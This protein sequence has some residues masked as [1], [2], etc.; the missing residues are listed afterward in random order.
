MK[1]IFKSIGHNKRIL[2]L[3]GIS[4]AYLLWGLIYIYHSSFIA[5]DGRRY[6]SLFDDAMI[7]MRYAWNFSHGLGL[8]WNQGE[9]V[10]GYTN[11]LMVLLM[12]ITTLLFDKSRAALAVQLSGIPIM[13]GIAWLTTRIFRF[14]NR[15]QETGSPELM[16][17]ILFLAVLAY[18]PLSFWS[19]T[20]METGLLALLLLGS[21]YA[22]L[23]YIEKQKPIFLLLTSVLLGFAFLTRNDA[24]IY[25]AWTFIYLG[26]TTLHK[27]ADL[28]RFVVN[29]AVFG[30]FVLI[31]EAIRYFYYGSLV[32]NT[33]V[34][35]LVGMSLANRL[36]N[37]WGFMQLFF[38]ESGFVLLVSLLGV[39]LN[40]SRSKLY[41]F[42]FGILSILYQ[43]YTGGDPWSYWRMMAPVMPLFLILFI[44]G[45]IAMIRKIPRLTQVKLTSAL[46][47][48]V[49]LAGLTSLDFR[50]IREM[51][52]VD[53]PYLYDLSS[54]QI[55]IA[56]AL[57]H[58]ARE[59]ATVGVFVAG[60][61]PYYTGLRA[62]DFLGKS[63]PYIANL[64]PDL[65]GDISASGMTS[66]PGH[67]KYDL[68]YSIKQLRPTYVQRFWWGSQN[69]NDWSKDYY[70]KVKYDWVALYLLKN[71][72]AVLW[73]KLK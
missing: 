39:G 65:S 43:L 73:K 3:F 48:I 35:K 47:V 57:N 27:R 50:F 17:C 1:D 28:Q 7:S 14:I 53:R 37:G 46:T 54:E 42:T 67:N 55:N 51:L 30:L 21:I 22:S 33:Y 60:V 70:V 38:I 5:I 36:E 69:L 66:P 6:F 64:P 34:L 16:G 58:V 44:I 8:V 32:P 15:D 13:L 63:D 71:S 10:E 12:S 29:L 40:I 24:F 52:L 59:D 9:R 61:V 4:F 26:A 62:I 25:A 18:Y 56:V 49:L 2:I 23:L 45:S 72:P 68:N 19:L 41:L 20:G 11:L 31:Q